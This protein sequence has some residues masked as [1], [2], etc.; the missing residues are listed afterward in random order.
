MSL[1]CSCR[2]FR[3]SGAAGDGTELSAEVTPGS[4][5]STL[6]SSGMEET[7]LIESTTTCHSTARMLVALGAGCTKMSTVSEASAN[8]ALPVVLFAPVLCFCSVSLR[9]AGS[10]SLA[11]LPSSC[12]SSSSPSVCSSSASGWSL[13]G[14]FSWRWARIGLLVPKRVVAVVL[15]EAV[16]ERRRRR[17]VLGLGEGVVRR[18]EEAVFEEADGEAESIPCRRSSS[19]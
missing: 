13:G 5:S 17:P 19:C 4:S 18:L 10:S 11:S 2:T 16:D 6:V 12:W 9:F 1:S 7:T 14:C 3:A 15:G 8:T